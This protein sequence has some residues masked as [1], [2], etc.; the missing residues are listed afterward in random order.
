MTP[1]EHAV[2]AAEAIVA[3]VRAKNKRL[4]AQLKLGP[5]HRPHVAAENA[6]LKALLDDADLLLMPG[7]EGLQ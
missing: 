2:A 4:S 7:P 1:R 6:R 5:A 3:E